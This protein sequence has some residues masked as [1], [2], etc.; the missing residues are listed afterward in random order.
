MNLQNFEEYCLPNT[1]KG[2]TLNNTFDKGIK[3]ELYP[4]RSHL[5]APTFDKGINKVSSLKGS[6][7]ALATLILSPRPGGDFI[8]DL[9]AGTWESSV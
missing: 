4:Q 5:T 9:A 3:E 7:F 1:Y 6:L 8:L 2:V